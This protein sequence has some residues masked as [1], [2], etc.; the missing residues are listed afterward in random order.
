MTLVL[1]HTVHRTNP[2]RIVEL[3]TDLCRKIVHFTASGKSEIFHGATLK[4]TIT[5]KDR[6]PKILNCFFTVVQKIVELLKIN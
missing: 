5:T 6:F 1:T 2:S 4:T 3:L